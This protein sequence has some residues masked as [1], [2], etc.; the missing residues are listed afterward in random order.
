M[1]NTLHNN[2]QRSHEENIFQRTVSIREII[3]K[4]LKNWYWFGISTFVFLCI[5]AFYLLSTSPV[6]HREA[7]V[8]I[9]DARRGS[10][11]SELS[12]FADI[13]GIS[14]RRSVDNELYVL[15]ARRL[16]LEVVDRLNLTHS[17]A[18][19]S[20]FRT[21]TLYKNSPIEAIYENN[22][23]GKSCSFTVLLGEDGVTISEFACA[24]KANEKA[25]KK[26]DELFTASAKYGEVINL[27]IGQV[28]I[29]TTL[30]FN[31][32]YV[33]KAKQVQD[34]DTYR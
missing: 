12:A 3:V 11:A 16:M 22:L 24:R 27:P 18:I 4:S 25:E 9:K 21:N 29:N 7:T 6:Y 10:A 13:A 28:V 5:G 1:E 17:Y 23:G 33:G 31:P 19:E 14:T 34:M 15:Q 32:E 26:S 30:Y 8:L 2:T 20:K